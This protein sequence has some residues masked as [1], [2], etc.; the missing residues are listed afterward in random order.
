MAFVAQY[1]LLSAYYSLTYSTPSHIIIQTM[2]RS[3]DI[4]LAE[5]RQFLL[6]SLTEWKD[7]VIEPVPLLPPT[8]WDRPVRQSASQLS[9]PKIISYPKNPKSSSFYSRNDVLVSLSSDEGREAFLHVTSC[10]TIEACCAEQ[11]HQRLSR[12]VAIYRTRRRTRCVTLGGYYLVDY[13]LDM[14]ITGRVMSL[15]EIIWLS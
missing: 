2:N 10:Q 7:E 5:V 6:K 14:T 9:E 1:Q 3:Q 4:K 15:F 8:N 11:S 13:G 12:H